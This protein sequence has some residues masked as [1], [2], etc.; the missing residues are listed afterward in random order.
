MSTEA[1]DSPLCGD[2]CPL[3]NLEDTDV[4]SAAREWA[5]SPP[6]E[7]KGFADP[8]FPM[9]GM[10]AMHYGSLCRARNLSGVCTK[11]AP[12]SIPPTNMA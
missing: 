9:L 6:H 11:E 3:A 1:F 2:T 12:E 8:R 5:F 10:M 4:A 7:H